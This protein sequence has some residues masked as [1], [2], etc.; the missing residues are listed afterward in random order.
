MIYENSWKKETND[1]VTCHIPDTS[2][3][4]ICASSVSTQSTFVLAM[5]LAPCANDLKGEVSIR[6]NGSQAL[7]N[8]DGP[9]SA[10]NRPPPNGDKT[11]FSTRS[12]RNRSHWT[13][14]VLSDLQRSQR[15]LTE[16][17]E[18]SLK[19]FNLFNW[20]PYSENYVNTLLSSKM[21]QLNERAIG[22]C[23]IEVAQCRAHCVEWEFIQSYESISGSSMDTNFWQDV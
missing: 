4:N 20:T 23:G 2:A 13:R 12:T 17:A 9:H 21:F 18:R 19:T 3:L 14:I 10:S 6:S 15:Y 1:R 11:I 7:S 5:A 22:G 16:M 8:H